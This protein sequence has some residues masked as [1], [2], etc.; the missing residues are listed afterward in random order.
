MNLEQVILSQNAKV[1]SDL[2]TLKADRKYQQD[3]LT[4]NI[5]NLQNFNRL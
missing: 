3:R 4:Y 5:L 2:E 1:N